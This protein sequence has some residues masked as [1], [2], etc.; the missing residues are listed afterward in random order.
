MVHQITQN[1][2]IW[3][4]LF[5]EKPA[6]DVVREFYGAPLRAI[7][8]P[9]VYPTGKLNTSLN[10][11]TDQLNQNWKYYPTVDVDMDQS[12]VAVSGNAIQAKLY[13]FCA[14]GLE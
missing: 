12:S 5:V 3:I 10:I 1:P 4:I 13:N 8:T 11:Y 7:S 9:V 6:D 2:G 14:I